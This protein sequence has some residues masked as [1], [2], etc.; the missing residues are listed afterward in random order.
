[1]SEQLGTGSEEQKVVLSDAPTI[2][3]LP[4]TAT[5]ADIAAMG[6]AINSIITALDNLGLVNQ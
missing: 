5:T 3:T 1:M 2:T 4:V 6:T